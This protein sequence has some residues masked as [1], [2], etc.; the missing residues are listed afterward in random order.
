MSVKLAKFNF[1]HE[2]RNTKLKLWYSPQKCDSECLNN[3]ENDVLTV[4]V[5]DLDDPVGSVQT[6]PS[7]HGHADQAHQQPCLLQCPG[8]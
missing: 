7:D 8:H 4:D 6:Q 3:D 2:E 5:V 1:W